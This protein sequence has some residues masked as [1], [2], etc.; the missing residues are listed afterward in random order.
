MLSLSVVMA[1]AA[2]V[3]G[4]LYGY[5][6]LGLPLAEVAGELV[7]SILCFADLSLTTYLV[8][9]HRA[10]LPF[11]VVQ[12]GNSFVKENVA[13][14]RQEKRPVNMTVP[15]VRHRLA[16]RI[17]Q[18]HVQI[19]PTDSILVTLD[20]TS[21]YPQSNELMWVKERVLIL[22]ECQACNSSNAALRTELVLKEN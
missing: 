17:L 10:V 12:E 13:G 4:S 21:Y 5:L 11:F 3:A 14:M 19:V 16:N 22:V 6:L 20:L 7:F 18:V 9:Q 1:V 8:S 15:L 2:P